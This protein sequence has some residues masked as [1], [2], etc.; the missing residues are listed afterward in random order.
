MLKMALNSQDTQVILPAGAGGGRARRCLRLRLRWATRR[1]ARAI[2]VLKLVGEELARQRMFLALHARR[3]R[4]AAAGLLAAGAASG[5]VLSAQLLGERL[6]RAARLS[7]AQAGKRLLSLMRNW[8]MS[9][10]DVS[11]QRPG[12]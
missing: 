6:R 2:F 9:A 5:R 1:L 10:A 4:L 8:H 3:H 7:A 12:E 11:M